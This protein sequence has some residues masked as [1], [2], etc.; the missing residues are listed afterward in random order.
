MAVARP[1]DQ[2]GRRDL[3]RWGARWGAGQP[4]GNSRYRPP[5][6]RHPRTYRRVR[7][8]IGCPFPVGS[9]R[10][11]WGRWWWQ[12]EVT[13]SPVPAR[14]IR[15]R[16]HRFSRA[17][18]SSMPPAFPSCLCSHCSAKAGRCKEKPLFA[19]WHRS[20]RVAAWGELLARQELCP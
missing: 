20:V 18:F 6:L 12:L 10:V 3:W 15:C 2:K 11:A 14:S 9:G 13:L 1:R 16:F 8:A 7:S 4:P 17:H 5:C 19:G